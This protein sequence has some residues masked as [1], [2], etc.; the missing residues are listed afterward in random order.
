MWLI[1]VWKMSIFPNRVSPDH[2]GA[3]LAVQTFGRS[4]VLLS[5]KIDPDAR[6]KLGSV[7]Q[8]PPF[9]IFWSPLIVV[10]M[11]KDGAAAKGE[12]GVIV[13]TVC[14]VLC[15][16][17]CAPQY[18]RCLDARDSLHSAVDAF[19]RLPLGHV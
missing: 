7:Q 2:L 12:Y 9:A 6:G 15:A 8:I 3:F 4:V 1:D 18:G 5:T 17:C 16:V 10:G 19:G 13:W 14:C 11:S